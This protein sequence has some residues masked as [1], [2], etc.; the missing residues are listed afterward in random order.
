MTGQE[1]ITHEIFNRMIILTA[2]VKHSEALPDRLF[3]SQC[4]LTKFPVQM[5]APHMFF[6]LR[7]EILTRVHSFAKPTCGHFS[8]Q[9]RLCPPHLQKASHLFSGQSINPTLTDSV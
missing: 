1:V 9:S 5:L 7:I 3:T 8:H 6:C 2:L 4:R